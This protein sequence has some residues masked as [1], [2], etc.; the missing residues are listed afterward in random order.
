MGAEHVL[1]RDNAQNVVHCVQADSR[2]STECDKK[3]KADRA[4]KYD[5]KNWR[6]PY[7]NK[8]RHICV[9]KSHKTPQY[10]TCYVQVEHGGL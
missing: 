8:Y 5:R 6:F 7:L 10:L 3:W 1:G 4:E 9:H 2:N